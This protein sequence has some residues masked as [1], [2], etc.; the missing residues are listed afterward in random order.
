MR[1]NVWQESMN[2]NSFVQGAY[3]IERM[4]KMDGGWIINYKDGISVICSESKYKELKIEEDG[5]FIKLEEHWFDIKEAIE[6]HPHL[7]VIK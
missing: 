6:E 2:R 7:E 1:F 3:L 5:K 4:K